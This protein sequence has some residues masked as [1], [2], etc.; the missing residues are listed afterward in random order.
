MLLLHLI[1]PLVISYGNV[2]RLRNLQETLVENG[3]L[4]FCGAVVTGEGVRILGVVDYEESFRK[5]SFLYHM[6]VT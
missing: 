3:N 1:A 5:L 4:N 2:I 6:S